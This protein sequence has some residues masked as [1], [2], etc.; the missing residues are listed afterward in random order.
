MIPRGP[1]NPTGPSSGGAQ[2]FTD[3]ADHEFIQRRLALTYG[4]FCA[5][6]GGFLVLSIV[7]TGILVPHRFWEL[8]LS[9]MRVLHVTSVVMLGA[10][11]WFCRGKLRSRSLLAAFDLFGL[12][13]IMT[14]SSFIIAF[15]PAGGRAELIGAVI[16][17]FTVTLR[18]ALV[19]SPPKWTVLVSAIAAIPVPFGAH[20][21]AERD[22]TWQVEL[23]PRAAAVVF[24]SGWCVAGTIAA[25]AISRVVYGLRAEVKSATRL[26]QYTLED[27]IGEGGMGEVYRARHALLRRPTAVKLLSPERAGAASVKRFEREVQLTSKL[28]HP[29]TIA[30]FDYGHTRDGVFYYAME[31]L[32][33]LSLHDLCDEDGPQGS[34]RVAHILAQVASALAEAHD[35]GLIHRDVKPANILLCERGGIPDF[36]KVLD[37]GLVKDSSEENADPA[38][39]SANAIAG[40]PLYMA[41]ESITR[42]KGIDA[43]VDLYAL[44][45]VGY[46]LLTARPPFEGASLV[47]ICSHH[48]HTTPTPPS[49]VLGRPVDA[50]LEALVLKCLAKSPA[51][52]PASARVLAD[53]LREVTAALPWTETEAREWWAARARKSPAEKAPKRPLD[54]AFDDTEKA[55]AQP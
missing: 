7:M 19:P 23:F 41:P 25:F 48:L 31:L 35:V 17:V 34:A 12:F 39:S 9:L 10:A 24:V 36:V 38:L 47:E 1:T 18:A 33:G 6:V 42:P 11:V 53:A 44:G 43:R 46:W 3:T 54:S 50:K 16:F 22:P 40:T 20:F 49:E 55:V 5:I 52:R 4:I 37:F 21:A 32:D 26:G 30:I 28:T 15:A 51:E 14:L 2:V 13:E 45:C 8:N 27:K 29:N